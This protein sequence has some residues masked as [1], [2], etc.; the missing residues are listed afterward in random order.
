MNR[1]I[2]I[3]SGKP[4]SGT[5]MMMKMLQE[6]GI[7]IYQTTPD[8]GNEFNPGGFFET[9]YVKKMDIYHG[10]ITEVYGKAMKVFANQLQNLPPSYYG[11]IT[12]KI[13]YMDRDP[14][15]SA[16]SFAN[17]QDRE[18]V[19]L[20]DTLIKENDQVKEDVDKLMRIRP[21]MSITYVNYDDV[22]SDATTKSQEIK[23]FLGVDLD[24]TKMSAVVN[25]ELRHF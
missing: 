4:R 24:V 20:D 7:E 1:I 8:Q 2:T 3:V 25:P 18:I 23:D 5:S 15:S 19:R 14:V 16:R 22:I 11:D 13:I 6:A 10:W 17:M 21:N 9:S 12:Y